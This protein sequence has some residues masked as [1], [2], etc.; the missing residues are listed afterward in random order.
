[1]YHLYGMPMTRATRVTWALEEIGAEYQ[2]HLVDLIKGQGQSPEFLRLNPFGK[3][4]V[5]VD[6]E[7]VLTE[8]GAI[9]TYLG[10][11]HP[12][13]GLVP[14]A[15][16]AQRGKYDQWCF[17]TLTELEQPLWTIHRHRF[18]YPE[19]KKVAQML[20]VAPWEFQRALTVLARGLGEQD[21]LLGDTF[22]MADILT[23]HTLRWARAAK[24]PLE[25]PE[26]QNY[27]QRVCSRAALAR[28]KEREKAATP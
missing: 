19:A 15:G 6:A 28:A 9:C 7:L 13:T 16:S 20:E 21:Y 24:L 1:M 27:E 23:A 10:D 2:Y 5:L 12:D 22:S 14:P 25:M 18:V 26:L 11:K 4:P 8:S 3:V 17:F